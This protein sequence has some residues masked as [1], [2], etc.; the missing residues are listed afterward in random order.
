MSVEEYVARH[1][2][3]DLPQ[4]LLSTLLNAM[5]L[6]GHGSLSHPLKV[7]FFLKHL[8]RS[9]DEIEAILAKLKIRTRK[10]KEEAEAKAEAFR[11][12]PM[13]EHAGEIQQVEAD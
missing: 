8:G 9:E 5:G 4:T 12:D 11:L 13:G 7:E 6:K 1:K 3:C 10:K 2:I